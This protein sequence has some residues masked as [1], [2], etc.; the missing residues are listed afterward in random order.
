VKRDGAAD[1]LGALLEAEQAR[2]PRWVCPSH[3]VVAYGDAKGATPC[4]NQNANQRG[5]RILCRIRQGLRDDVVRG[6]LNLLGQTRVG[7]HR[8]LNRDRRTV[9][10]RLERR[11]ESIL[12][13]DR[14]MNPM[15]DLAQLIEQV[16]VF[17]DDTGELCAELDELRR[18]HR[19]YGANAK[20]EHDQLLL[21]AVVQ[22]AL[23]ATT[24]R[25]C[26]RDYLC[27]RGRGPGCSTER[28]AGHHA[29]TPG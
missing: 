11:L 12:G 8:Q 13:Q 1:C 3:T 10:E 23:D 16:R 14:R 5:V 26:D 7:A 9:G 2:T 19:L 25:I 22:V 21:E 17:V 28:A 20:R 18:H 24:G 4:L 15:R 29:P 27:R 6:Q